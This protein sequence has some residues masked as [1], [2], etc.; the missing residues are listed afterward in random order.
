MSEPARAPVAPL[1]VS[2]CGHVHAPSAALAG[3]IR[4]QTFILFSQV[5]RE[6]VA[7]AG[8]LRSAMSNALEVRLAAVFSL[9]RFGLRNGGCNG[10]G[11]RRTCARNCLRNGAGDCP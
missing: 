2:A 11:S 1:A 5:S 6:A 8:R 7:A 3:A 9:F 10:P 4:C